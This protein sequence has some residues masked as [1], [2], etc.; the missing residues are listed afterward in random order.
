MKTVSG[1]FDTHKEASMAVDAL[2]DAGI[3]SDEI[4]VVGPDG[5]TDASGAGGGRRYWRR[6]WRRGRTAREAW[7]LSPFQVLDRSLAPAG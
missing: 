1:L 2:E 3:A 4:S 6:G 7:A 5:N